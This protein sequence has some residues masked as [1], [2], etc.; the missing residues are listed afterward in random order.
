MANVTKRTNKDGDISYQIRVFVDENISGKQKVKSK[1]YKPAKNLSEKQIQKELDKQVVQFEQQIKQGLMG[2][3]GTIK[4]AEYATMWLDNAQIAPKT[5]EVYIV[6]LERINQAI[7]HIKLQNIQAFHLESF[8]KNLKEGGIKKGTS[9][10]QSTTIKEILK[11][12]KITDVELSKRSKVCATTISTIRKGDIVSLATA[13][14]I[15][16]A[17]ELPVTPLFTV[18]TK[19]SGLSD[20]TILHHHRLISTILG[21]AKREQVI[22]FNVAVEHTNSPKVKKKEAVYLDDVQAQQVVSLLFDEEDVRVKTALLVLIATGLRRG[23]LCGLEWADIDFDNCLIHVRRASQ[24]QIGK[25]IVEVPTKNESSNRAVKTPAFVFDILSDYKK[26]WRSQQFINGSKWQGQASR[27]FIQEDGK[28]ISPD[29][30]NFWLT[31]FIEK[32]NLPYFT[33]HSLRHTF[34][35]LQ[36]MAGVNIRTIQARTGHSQASTLVN[37]Y[38]HAI[39][40]ADEM[41]SNALSDILLPQKTVLKEAK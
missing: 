2:Y 11:D 36:I 20:K 19:K 8:Y 1:T 6:L 12:L 38:S 4:F 18:S 40:T 39:K 24:Y 41:A 30:I 21:K 13:Q 28:P 37:V 22:P 9:T 34:A 27:L 14:K 33:P 29:T 23:E 31:K 26:W 25:G 10:A 16:S 5:K 35:T 7:G 15:A 3:D 32:H 17:L